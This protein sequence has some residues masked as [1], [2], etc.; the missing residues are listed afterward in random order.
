[1]S[2]KNGTELTV[3]PYP[4]SYI[5]YYFFSKLA[6]ILMLE[7]LFPTHGKIFYSRKACVWKKSYLPW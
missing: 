2:L 6:N 1:M 3:K 4:F 7:C 5:F